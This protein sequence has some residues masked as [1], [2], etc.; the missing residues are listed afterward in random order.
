M[1]S[2]IPNFEILRSLRSVAKINIIRISQFPV[3]GN[4]TFNK[5]LIWGRK[6]LILKLIKK[7]TMNGMI[8]RLVKS[9]MYIFS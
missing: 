7:L 9:H 3:L 4:K 5:Y 1:E 2:V 6:K 8:N